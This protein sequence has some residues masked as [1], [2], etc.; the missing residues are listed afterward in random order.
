MQCPAIAK[1]TVCLEA[2]V[3]IVPEVKIGR[4]LVKCKGDPFIGRC[5]GT[6]QK[7]CTFFVSQRIEVKVPLS[8]DVDVDA[9]PNGIVC[10][11]PKT[12]EMK[13]DDGEC[14]ECL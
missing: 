10:G 5:P 1:D 11:E 4:I 8:F 9:E 6:P 7:A 12:D 2:Q 3:K 13:D 14:T